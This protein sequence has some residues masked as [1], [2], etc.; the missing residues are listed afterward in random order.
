MKISLLKAMVAALLL[1]TP[2]MGKGAVSIAYNGI[3]LNEKGHELSSLTH[4]IEF[5]IYDQVTGGSNL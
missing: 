3:L 1:F 4:S 2:A 5:N